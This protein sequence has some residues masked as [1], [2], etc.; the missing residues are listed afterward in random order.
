MKNKQN[1]VKRIITI[2]IS[3]VTIISIILGSYSLFFYINSGYLLNRGN[4]E[5]D[6]LS[7]YSFNDRTNKKY[8]IMIDT[9]KYNNDYKY[10]F[11]M[12]YIGSDDNPKLY[13]EI[14]DYINTDF[15]IINYENNIAIDRN[16]NTGEITT[17]NDILFDDFINGLLI[18]N[19][20]YSKANFSSYS[21]RFSTNKYRNFLYYKYEFDNYYTYLYMNYFNVNVKLQILS[22]NFEYYIYKNKYTKKDQI[23]LITSYNC[24][25]NNNNFLIYSNVLIYL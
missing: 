18:F 8:L 23:N 21:N 16:C 4:F 15:H 2:T 20:D 10:W 11:D 13:L 6:V 24:M 1:I 7:K 19:I 9:N 5:K 14:D 22:I 25:N 3:L 17:K 12:Q